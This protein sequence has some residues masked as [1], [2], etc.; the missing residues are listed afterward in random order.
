[1]ET[2]R[3][4]R[5]KLQAGHEISGPAVIL[6]HNST[7]LVPPGYRARVSDFGNIHIKSV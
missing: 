7:T 5:G 6:Q 3:Y 1:V 4:D 2:P